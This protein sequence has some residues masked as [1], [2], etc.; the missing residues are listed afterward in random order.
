MERRREDLPPLRFDCGTGDHLAAGNRLLHEALVA[1]DIPHVYAE[2]PGGHTWEYWEA[3]L[4]DTLVFFES[5]LRGA[6]PSTVS[7]GS[8]GTSGDAV[9]R[10]SV[11]AQ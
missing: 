8:V 3:H 11:A 5:V 6:M 10:P 7:G 2:Y 1:S 9:R 4:E